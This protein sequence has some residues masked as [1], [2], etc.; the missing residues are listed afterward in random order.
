M[1]QPQ[2]PLRVA[3]AGCH[4][5]LLH[6]PGSHNF[7][8]A[9]AAVPDTQIVAVFDHGA[10]D[11]ARF[12][13]CWRDTWG[14]IPTYGD[15]QAMLNENQPDLLCIATRQTMHTDQ[16]EQAVQA[17]VRGILC[18]KPLATS[19]AETDR[20]INACVNT[21]L[22]FG[23]DRRWTANYQYLREEIANGLIGPATSITAYNL[24]NTVNHGCHWNDTVLALV[25]DPEPVW[26]SG[27][28]AEVDPANER[29][30]IDPPSRTLICLDNG[31]VAYITPDGPPGMGFEIVG[32]KGRLSVGNDATDAHL[33]LQDSGQSRPLPVPPPG[34]N[35]PAGTAMVQD[36]VQA[37][38]NGR[39]SLCDIDQARRA[40]EIS[41]AIH[42][43]SAQNGAKILLPAAERS[44]V[45]ESFVWGNE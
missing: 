38:R 23:L 33:W 44:L 31:V 4:R 45:V 2:S 5:M 3:I 12:A 20:I 28:L 10:E 43:S 1:P 26:V 14:Q 35:W 22:V 24:P 27:L 16:I 40:T 37:V 21:P 32:E 7:A 34:E 41:F 8:T 9:F 19:L 18:D 25:G 30:L 11:R 6:T 29:S 13:D 15:Y 39:R 42:N 17:G 36:L